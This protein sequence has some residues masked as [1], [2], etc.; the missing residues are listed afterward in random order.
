[1]CIGETDCFFFSVL[2]LYIANGS[3]E[4]NELNSEEAEAVSAKKSCVRPR[5]HKKG[6]LCSDFRIRIAPGAVK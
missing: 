4:A 6:V 1:M 2:V 3:G 5:D